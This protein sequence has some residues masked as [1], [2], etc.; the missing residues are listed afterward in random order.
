GREKAAEECRRHA[1]QK[2]SAI[3]RELSALRFGNV[4]R[5]LME[6]ARAIQR[7]EMARAASKLRALDPSESEAVRR[8]S[9]RIAARLIHLPLASIREFALD[10]RGGDAA[11]WA[12]RLF[13]L[14]SDG[15]GAGAE[16]TGPGADGADGGRRGAYGEE[17][18]GGPDGNPRARESGGRPPL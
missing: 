5:M 3:F 2:A 13:G 8:M 14:P 16:E 15:P 1:R 4:S 7:E 9:A 18:S 12:A 6:K 17:R 11:E 10:G